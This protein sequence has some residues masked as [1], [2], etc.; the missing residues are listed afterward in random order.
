MKIKSIIYSVLGM[1]C[2]SIGLSSCSDFLELEPQN[3]IILEKFW[4][5][6]A[7]V[8]GMIAGCYSGMQSDNMMLRMMIWGEFR[9]DNISRGQNLEKDLNIENILKENIM[10]SNGYTTWEAFYDI[11]NR[12]NTVMK[13][14]P[15][16]AEKDPSFSESE[17]KA[18]I[19]EVTALRALC[20]FYLIRTFRDVPYS[21]EAFTDDDQVMDLPATSFDTV[22]DSLIND[23]ERVKD[24]AVEKYPEGS[25]VKKLYQTARI[26]KMAIHAM[27]CEMYLWKKDYNT[28]IRYA[29]LIIEEKKKQAEE[30]NANSM[31]ATDYRKTNGYPL[32]PTDYI[33]SP[34]I[35]GNA[36]NRIF[37]EGNSSESIF[38]L[39]F[40]DDDNMLSNGAVSLCYGNA[41]N[42]GIMGYASVSSFISDDIDSKSFEVFYNK[43]DVRAYEN[44]MGNVIAKYT[45]T[46][47]QIDFS[48]GTVGWDLSG[49][50]PENKVKTN[51]II[52]RLS[53]I[54][55]LKAEALTQLISNE[56]TFTEQ[57]KQYYQQAFSLV[58]AVNK[59][60]LCQPASQLKDT[61]DASKFNTKDG[62]E[63]LV[64]KERHRE[65]MFEGKRW[66]D[67]VRRS[68]RDGN[69]NYL[70]AQVL[71]KF[72]SNTSAIQNKF[73]KMDAVFWPYNVDELKVNKNLHQNPAFGSG[74][75]G[76]YT[77]D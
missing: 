26:T 60:S 18:D 75:N 27:L 49:F 36:Y 14:A 71:Q 24:D 8:D 5:E 2:A 38:E 34:S 61:L 28:S 70:V 22:L 47:S 57:D 37:G 25:S 3:E 46:L 54:M 43:Y 58:N 66:Y 20:Y 1:A 4:N 7:D 31:L 35:Y 16:V 65:L 73:R 55:L 6:K 56:E 40:M 77:K 44:I 69:T 33:S 29:D 10:A 62:I 39:T 21:T 67:L 30:E 76:N 64:M 42:A 9:S 51:W 52:Y 72:T 12:C 13:Y 11:I 15:G 48:S 59:R 23:L 19:A 50:F 68:M 32:I 41:K 45:H 53:D 17:L 63:T 74:E